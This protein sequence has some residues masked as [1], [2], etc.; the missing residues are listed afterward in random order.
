VDSNIV[1]IAQN[2]DAVTLY[3]YE[4]ASGRRLA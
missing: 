4:A 1:D 2:G 3:E